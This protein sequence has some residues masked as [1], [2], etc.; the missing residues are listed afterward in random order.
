MTVED[1]EH[2]L[3]RDVGKLA[4]RQCRDKGVCGYEHEVG[5]EGHETINT[6]CEAR[7]KRVG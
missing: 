5:E 1:V 6:V 3:E 2:I 4:E 7:E